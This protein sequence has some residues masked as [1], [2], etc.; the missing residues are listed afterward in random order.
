MLE[1]REIYHRFIKSFIDAISSFSM[2]PEKHPIVKG[3]LASLISIF[4]QIFELQDKDLEISIKGR[5]L[6]V[7]GIVLDISKTFVINFLSYMMKSE[8][9]NFTVRRSCTKDDVSDL[10]SFFAENARRHGGMN[11]LLNSQ[12]APTFSLSDSHKEDISKEP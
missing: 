9:S 3:A 12:E 4:E 11:S 5:N 6:L 1:E 7:N 10:V 2:Y 8:L